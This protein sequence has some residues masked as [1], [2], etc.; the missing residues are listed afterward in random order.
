MK[1]RVEHRWD[2]TPQGAAR[3]QVELRNR[4]QA[5]PDFGAV[6]TVAGTDIAVDKAAGVGFAGVIVYWSPPSFTS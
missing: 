4:I 2:L 3:L 5:Q 1:P 6:R